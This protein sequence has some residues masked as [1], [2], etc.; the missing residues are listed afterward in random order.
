MK[1]ISVIIPSYQHSKE[2]AGCLDSIF[3]QTLSD[4]EVIVVN[5]GSTDDT[6][7]VLKPYAN[8]ITLIDQENQ[9]GNAAR[10]RGFEASEASLLIFSDADLLWKSDAF[11]KMVNAL[12][13]HPEASYAYSSFRFGWKKF[14][15]WAFDERRLKD[16]PYIHTS[17]LIRREHFPGFDETLKRLQDWDLWLTMLEQE[18]TGTW[19]DEVLFK[20]LPKKNLLPWSGISEWMPRFVHHIPWKQ[21]GFKPAPVSRY[22][23]AIAIVKKKHGLL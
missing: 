12:E 4:I 15:L 13:A 2:I 7:D 22:D 3:S 17:A 16:A 8:R 10:N 11:E 18:H 6:L 20:A 9:G 23:A 1:K 14:R 19:I 21:L 5:D